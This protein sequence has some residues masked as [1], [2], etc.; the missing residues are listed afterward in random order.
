MG[1]ISFVEAFAYLTK[2]DALLCVGCATD[3]THL[4][5]EG[6]RWLAGLTPLDEQLFRECV[7]D[8]YGYDSARCEECQTVLY[9]GLAAAC[10]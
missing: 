6:R 9:D 8:V 3:T 7:V 10:L 5:G 1:T 4:V 2:Y